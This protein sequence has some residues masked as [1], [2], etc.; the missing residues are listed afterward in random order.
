MN[1]N[2]FKKH[3]EKE[4]TK[5]REARLAYYAADRVALKAAKIADIAYAAARAA[6]AA[7]VDASDAN[8]CSDA[9]EDAYCDAAEYATNLFCRYN[10][11]IG[12]RIGR[13]G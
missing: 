4:T 12:R 3:S 7:N 2:R 5:Q 6:L 11:T 8:A 9:A 10:R 13:C 1:A